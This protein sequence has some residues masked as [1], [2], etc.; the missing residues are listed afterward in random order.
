MND[1]LEMG[2]R[3][4]HEHTQDD[5]LARKLAADHL[6]EDPHYYSKLQAAGLDEDNSDDKGWE[7]YKKAHGDNEIED[8][9][10]IKHK[11][12]DLSWHKPRGKRMGQ[13]V[14]ELKETDMSECDGPEVPPVGII[15]VGQ[16][17]MGAP[18]P[19][20]AIAVGSAPAGQ[21]KLTS[22]GLGKAGVNKP[23]VSDKLEAPEAKKVGANKI[24]TSKTPPLSAPSSLSGDSATDPMDHFGSAIVGLSEGGSSIKKK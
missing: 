12:K 5:A 3:I 22:S 9:S 14:P 21:S 4:E 10:G 11:V 2:T 1:E 24:A 7:D 18:A 8:A 13:N 19:V 16:I 23:L 15:K 20:T 17:G 6:R